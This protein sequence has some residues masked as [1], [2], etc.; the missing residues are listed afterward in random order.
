DRP[1]HPL[2]AAVR[3]HPGQAEVAGLI[4][5]LVDGSGLAKQEL[6][7]HLPR[8][9]GVSIQD[10]YSLR[11]IAQVHAVNVEKLVAAARTLE[12]N[13]NAVSDNPLWVPPEHTI[14]GEDP[15][16]WVSG[17]NF[18][19]APPAEVMDGLRKTLTQIVKLADRQL[20]RLVSPHMNNG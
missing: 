10:G 2:L 19:A 17:A 14:A 12:V 1:Y 13:I 9:A 5:Y 16:G 7:G 15:W 11:G 20:A 3:P 6:R 4:R 18:L 8:E